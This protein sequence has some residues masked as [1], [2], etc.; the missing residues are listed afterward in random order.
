MSKV[1]E[2]FS[3]ARGVITFAKDVADDIPRP[4]REGLGL[5]KRKKR[6]VR[7]RKEQSPVV[8]VGSSGKER[9]WSEE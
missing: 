3:A 2:P 4:G 8:S 5:T 1:V 6:N 9:T 7:Y